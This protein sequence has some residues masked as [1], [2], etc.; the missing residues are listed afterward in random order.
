MRYRVRVALVNLGAALLIVFA[1]SNV[2]WR[3]PWSRILEAFAV[4]AL[5]STC[6]V[7][8]CAYLIPRLA[9]VMRRRVHESLMWIV[10]VAAMTGIAV[11]G[12]ATALLVMR[13]FGYLPSGPVFRT[14]FG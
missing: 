2:G 1:F 12:T 8:P 5:M 6:I 14:W 11:A 10:L 13:T 9:Q 3:T 7:V 4:A